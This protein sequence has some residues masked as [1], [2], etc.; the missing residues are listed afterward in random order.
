MSAGVVFLSQRCAGNIGVLKWKVCHGGLIAWRLTT[1]SDALAVVMNANHIRIEGVVSTMATREELLIIRAAR[2]GQA[3]AQVALGKRYL[4]GG[5]GLPRSPAT[6][7]YWL[8]RAANQHERDAWMLIGSYVPFEV[9]RGV[10]QLSRLRVWYEKAFDA[11]MVQAGLVFAKLVLQQGQNLLDPVLRQKALRALEAAARAGIA[12]AQWLLAQQIGGA[13]ALAL[14]FAH[15][16][17]N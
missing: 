14:G 15:D 17:R 3:S 2:A 6:A 7:L 8:D 10:P 16:H 4:F 5:T 11:G 12:D 9:A 1:I 13:A